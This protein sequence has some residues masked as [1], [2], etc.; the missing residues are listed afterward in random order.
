M[1]RRLAIAL[2]VSLIAGPALGAERWP[3]R[4][5][6][7]FQDLFHIWDF[8]KAAAGG[9]PPDFTALQMGGAQTAAIWM[10][11]PDPS[12]P[13]PPNIVDQSAP[14]T[15]GCVQLLLANGLVYGYPDLST[16]IRLV[17]GAA[18]GSS[19]AGG[20]VFGA[21]DGNNFYAAVVSAAGDT[22]ELLRVVDGKP[23]VLAQKTVKPKKVA[24]HHLRVQR[25]TIISKE[26]I[27]V[28]F[29]AELVLSYDEKLLEPGQIGIMTRGDALVGFDH[30]HAA[31]LY[32]QNPLSPPAAY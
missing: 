20:L 7:A 6:T 21:R 8:D 17:P 11:K 18:A 4:D 10:V 14:C 25:N 27:E 32:S 15:D 5:S 3:K 26:Y 19:G 13:S 12:A 9:P 28:F 30:L 24:W 2:I 23:T 31:P 16:R 22:V 29:D 1:M